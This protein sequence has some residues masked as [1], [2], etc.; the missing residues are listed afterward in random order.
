MLQACEDFYHSHQYKIKRLT[1]LSVKT[2]FTLSFLPSESNLDAYD[3]QVA[4]RYISNDNE[5]L[6]SIVAHI[7]CLLPSFIANLPMWAAIMYCWNRHDHLISAENYEDN[8]EQVHHHHSFMELLLEFIVIGGPFGLIGCAAFLDTIG[9]STDVSD[10]SQLKWILIY[11]AAALTGVV[12]AFANFKLHSFHAHKGAEEHGGGIQ[13]FFKSLRTTF[14]DNILLEKNKYKSHLTQIRV[15]LHEIYLKSIIVAVHGF[16]GYFA[17]DVFLKETGLRNFPYLNYPLKIALP[18]AVT[19]FEGNTEARSLDDHKEKQAIKA[20]SSSL[21][22]KS[23]V[24]L[25]GFFHTIPAIAAFAWIIGSFDSGPFGGIL[26]N[27]LVFAVLAVFFGYPS[28]RGFYATTLEG[29]DQAS[30]GVKTTIKKTI[31]GEPSQDVDYESIQG[32]QR[33]TFCARLLS[34]FGFHA[35]NQDEPI[36][37]QNRSSVVTPNYYSS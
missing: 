24:L 18:L 27:L 32:D 36:L 3:T 26:L 37:L 22:S 30:I 33:P 1:L 34:K 13:A 15:V 35:T 12:T 6:K 29:F 25:A 8:G 31:W 7:V 2:L 17:A 20:Y 28:V 9:E 4:L 5:Q 10:L 11:I 16:M 19:V 14:V 23:I 21:S